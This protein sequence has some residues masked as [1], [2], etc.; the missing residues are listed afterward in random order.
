MRES[1]VTE[2]YSAYPPTHIRITPR[3][4]RSADDDCAAAYGALEHHDHDEICACSTVNTANGNR[5][6]EPKKSCQSQFWATRGQP[7]ART[8]TARGFAKRR[9]Y[10]K[11]LIL[12]V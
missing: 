10:K 3:N 7:V 11:P 4:E 8:A 1:G 9:D 2:N 6:A 12:A 5:H